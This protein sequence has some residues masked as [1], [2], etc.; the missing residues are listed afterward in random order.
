MDNALGIIS[1]IFVLFFNVLIYTQLTVPK[2]DNVI[3]KLL[4]YV[5]STLDSGYVPD[6]V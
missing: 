5:G 2:K 6:F 1:E 3:T 4:M